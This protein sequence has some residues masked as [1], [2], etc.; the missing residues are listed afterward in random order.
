MQGVVA[1]IA[2]PAIVRATSLMPVRAYSDELVGYRKIAA[3][4][5]V[6]DEMMADGGFLVPPEFSREIWQLVM[7]Q[8]SH[9]ILR[10]L[11]LER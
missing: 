9:L 10:C 5:P 6:T 4:M 7:T 1:L 3:L 2:A 11:P 8:E